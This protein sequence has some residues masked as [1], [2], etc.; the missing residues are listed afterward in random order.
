MPNHEI[1]SPIY[2]VSRNVV[3]IAYAVFLAWRS[4][5]ASRH[6]VNVV[7]SSGTPPLGI[8]TSPA[9]RR[10]TWMW[11]KNTVCPGASPHADVELSIC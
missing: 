10:A 1:A 7:E 5:G 11:A 4:R 8:G 3:E 6:G 9:Y 2:F